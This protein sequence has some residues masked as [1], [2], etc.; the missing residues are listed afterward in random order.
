MHCVLVTS[1]INQNN[2]FSL[3]EVLVA[4]GLLGLLS[5]GIA[6]MFS[7]QQKEMKALDEKFI[8]QSLRQNVLN[9]LQS[10]PVCVSNLGSISADISTATTTTP[11]AGN[12]VFTELHIGTGPSTPLLAKVNMSLPGRVDEILQNVVDGPSASGGLVM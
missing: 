8:L 1:K 11:S 3:I 7:Q 5:L 9:V 2:G 6:S 10:K 12:F 4:A